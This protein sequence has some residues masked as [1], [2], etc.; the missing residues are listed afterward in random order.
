MRVRETF[1]RDLIAEIRAVY[2]GDLTYAANWYDDFEHIPFWDALDYVGVQAY[3]PLS[4]DEAPTVEALRAGWADHETSLR[5]VHEQTGKPVLFTEIGYRDVGHAAARP[6]EWPER[7]ATPEADEALQAR[8]YT[9][10]FEEVW[11]EPWLAGAMLWKFY[12]P[13]DRDHAGDF[14]PQG[15]AAEAVIQRYFAAGRAASP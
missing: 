6:W 5:A 14:T 13:S 12:P 11:P 10:F 4:E 3:F 7:H 2:D 8:L 9:A 1:W 15:K